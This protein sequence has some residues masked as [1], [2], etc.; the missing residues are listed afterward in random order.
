[1]ESSGTPAKVTLDLRHPFA[2]GTL[3][4]KVDE[5]VV[6]ASDIH[7]MPIRVEGVPSGYDGRFGADLEI[8][9]GD[10]VILVEVRSGPTEFVE[11]SRVQ[12]RGGQ[13][14]RLVALVDKSL[15]LTFH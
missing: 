10:H 2:S 1:M 12:L 13:T 4:V 14:R 8:P 6:F 7:G 9:P 3:R 5:K 15:T 11:S